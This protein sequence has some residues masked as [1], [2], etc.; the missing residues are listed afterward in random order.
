MPRKAC[1][2]PEQTQDRRTRQVDRRCTRLQQT[3]GGKFHP[4]GGKSCLRTFRLWSPMC[5][6]PMTA[7]NQ[8][9]VRR[10]ADWHASC[11]PSPQGYYRGTIA[12]V[13]SRVDTEQTRDSCLHE[14]HTNES[15]VNREFWAALPAATM[16]PMTA[17]FRKSSRAGARIR[18]HATKREYILL[19]RKKRGRR[20]RRA[21]PLTEPRAA[22]NLLVCRLQP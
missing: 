5:K 16:A 19:K 21:G 22:S 13:L 6:V 10:V 17:L 7:E 18:T 3:V 20:G 12:R 4:S 14:E 9:I 1:N 15:R 8:T 11:C 2:R